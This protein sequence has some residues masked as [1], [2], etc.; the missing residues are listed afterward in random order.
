MRLPMPK[1]Y[2]YRGDISGYISLLQW[3]CTAV[4]D[5]VTYQHVHFRD[6]TRIGRNR[7]ITDVFVKNT[8]AGTV[9]EAWIQPKRKRLA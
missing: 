8:P 5:A 7:A 6:F 2:Q 1:L 9:S 4:A 3:S